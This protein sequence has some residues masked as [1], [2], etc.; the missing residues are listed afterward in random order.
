ME[1]EFTSWISQNFT[2]PPNT[3]WTTTVNSP[4]KQNIGYYP[5]WPHVYSFSVR[6]LL[7]D[8]GSDVPEQRLENI[9]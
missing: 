9:I 7:E 1:H 8:F 3:S 2:W 6:L 5:Y 4:A